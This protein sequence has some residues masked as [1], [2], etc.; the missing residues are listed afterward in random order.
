MP[1]NPSF[2][3]APVRG[4]WCLAGL[5]VDDFTCQAHQ[6]LHSGCWDCWSSWLVVHLPLA[7]EPAQQGLGCGW[8]WHLLLWS[9]APALLCSPWLF[10]RDSGSDP[11]LQPGL[12]QPL[13]VGIPAGVAW[14]NKGHE[15]RMNWGDS[16][17]FVP[18]LVLLLLLH[19]CCWLLS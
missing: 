1:R 5:G 3:L 2:C 8:E 4:G 15:V 19:L 16:D 6:E 9:L 11:A 14:R 17:F 7:Q 18:A 10:H 13:P 12:A